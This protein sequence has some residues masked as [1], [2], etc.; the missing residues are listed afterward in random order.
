MA[1]TT[2]NTLNL[3]TIGIIHEFHYTH[4]N[5]VSETITK[6][7]DNSLSPYSESYLKYGCLII[8]SRRDTQYYLIYKDDSSKDQYLKYLKYLQIIK[9]LM[10][11]NFKIDKIENIIRFLNDT[12]FE[13]LKNIYPSKIKCVNNPS[14][15]RDFLLNYKIEM[16]DY[17]K[18]YNN[19]PLN[20]LPRNESGNTYYTF[21]L[22]INGIHYGYYENILEMGTAH[23]FL[24]DT[25]LTDVFIAGEIKIE[26]QTIIF[27][28]MSGT[29]SA[30]LNLD[31][32]PLLYR[33]YIELITGILNLHRL[34]LKTRFT[35]IEFTEAVLF[36]KLPPTKKSIRHMCLQP[37]TSNN[38]V[39]LDEGVR[40]V[41][42]S[43]ADLTPDQKTKAQT[44]LSAG[45]NL[46]CN[47]KDYQYEQKYIKYKN[48]YLKLKKLSIN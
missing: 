38:V 6:I 24:I 26:G 8:Q 14:G 2:S 18:I 44:D 37:Y 20:S 3:S 40:C 36:E 29:F 46:I 32:K 11:G 1:L 17:S 42:N 21:L 23:Q 7:N 25:D 30:R 34:D 35:Y 10:D 48:K 41:N 19:V 43:L 33:L 4:L 9:P 47:D 12:S 15:S 13:K 16:K 28:F 45:R 27:N 39:V 22:D 5:S 31:R